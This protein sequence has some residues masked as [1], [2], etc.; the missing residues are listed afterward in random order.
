MFS[1]ACLQVSLMVSA[2]NKSEQ[3]PNKLSTD[4]FAARM[5]P[6]FSNQ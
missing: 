4:F 6:H 3:R 2:E 5:P 1:L